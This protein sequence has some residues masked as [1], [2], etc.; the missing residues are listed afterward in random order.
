MSVMWCGQPVDLVF[1]AL[2]DAEATARIGAASHE[3]TQ[4]RLTRNGYRDRVLT[5]ATG[6]VEL[7]IPKLRADSFFPFRHCWSGAVASIRRRSPS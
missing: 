7:G 4:T 6:D 5:T 1:Q 3:R 2:I